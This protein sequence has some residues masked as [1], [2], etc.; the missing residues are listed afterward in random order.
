MSVCMSV[1]T[2]DDELVQTKSKLTLLP[3]YE[4]LPMQ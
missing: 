3:H 2:K 4:N 1:N